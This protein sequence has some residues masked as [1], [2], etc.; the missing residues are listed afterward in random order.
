MVK[1]GDTNESLDCGLKKEFGLIEVDS[2]LVE[3]HEDTDYPV[4]LLQGR[5]SGQVVSAWI[6][7]ID[8][9]LEISL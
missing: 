9:G 3:P 5:I 4:Y 7:E 1:P 6:G 2:C 8:L